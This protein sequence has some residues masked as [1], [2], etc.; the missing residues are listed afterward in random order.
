VIWGS[1][2]STFR[3]PLAPDG[4]GELPVSVVL[5]D[6]FLSCKAE[7]FFAL[8]AALPRCV[9]PSFVEEQQPEKLSITADPRANE[10]AKRFMTTFRGMGGLLLRGGSRVF[11]L[12]GIRTQG[13]RYE[14]STKKTTELVLNLKRKNF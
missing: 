2:F 10:L 7:G 12:F 1:V 13:M 11:L 14:I 8:E 6:G 5:T 9:V 3:P 4:S